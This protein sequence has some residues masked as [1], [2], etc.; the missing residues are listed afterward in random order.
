MHSDKNPNPQGKGLVPV[1]DDWQASR[2]TQLAPKPIGQWLLDWFASVVVLS[3]T[4]SFKPAVGQR[5]FLYW[6]RESWKLSLV[7]PEEWGSRPVGDCLGECRMNP[8]M[9]WTI[10]AAEG[11]DAKPELL[12]ALQG[13]VEGFLCELEDDAALEERLP[14]YRRDLPYYQ[15]MLA[16]ALG[17]S[18]RASAEN[19]AMLVAPAAQLLETGSTDLLRRLTAPSGS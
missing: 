19:Q 7:S 13:M 6:W 4:F 3:S 1:L 9:T 12:Q 17:K 5:Y 10:Q 8:D 2:P 16:T 15:R 14:G 18:L 11:L